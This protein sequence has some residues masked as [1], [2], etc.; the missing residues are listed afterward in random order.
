[1][2][3]NSITTNTGHP[4]GRTITGSSGRERKSVYP[5][6]NERMNYNEQ[7]NTTIRENSDGRVSFKGGIKAPPLHNIAIKTGDYP[8][9][10][11]AAFA[12]LITCGL[13]PLTILA[14]A[15]SKEDKEK[16]AYQVGKSVAS[17]LVG[18]AVS[19][20]IGAPMGKATKTVN[21]S[22]AFTIPEN[23]K[24]TSQEAVDKG[25][26]ILKNISQQT[27]DSAL[28]EQIRKGID[29]GNIT[30]T[31]T[32]IKAAGELKK[33]YKAIKKQ[34][35][36]SLKD[37]KNAV[38]AQKVLNNYEGATKNLMDKLFQPIIAPV[39]ATITIA[40]VPVILGA[41]IGLKHK[42]SADKQVQTQ[43]N[44]Y[45][46]LKYHVFQ[47]S[48]EKELFQSFSGVAKYENK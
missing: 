20:L 47:S 41:F 9:I 4:A 33:F 27:T 38:N 18:L 13:R 26:Q 5:R 22:G 39:K 24:K 42:K 35:P 10:A 36:E 1:M 45:E 30:S 43:N 29:N 2:K 21:N 14:T 32:D 11:E 16:S 17:G 15:R 23:I 31:L 6:N 25:I 48:R 19:A 3:I 34:S 8:L 28:V 46:S 7:I 12:V 37:V 44:P 40:A